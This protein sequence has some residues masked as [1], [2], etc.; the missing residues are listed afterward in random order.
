MYPDLRKRKSKESSN[1]IEVLKADFMLENPG[2]HQQ[3]VEELLDSILYQE[4]SY[5]N[6]LSHAVPLDKSINNQISRFGSSRNVEAVGREKNFMQTVNEKVKRDGA[7]AS[8]S[9]ASPQVFTRYQP[10]NANI[11]SPNN[12]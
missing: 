4:L 12:Q 5:I 3:P 10:N 7:V 1:S 9:P 8:A 2:M 6:G 11:Q